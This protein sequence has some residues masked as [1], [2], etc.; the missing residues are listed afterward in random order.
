MS[1]ACVLLLLH[2]EHPIFPLSITLTPAPRL[3]YL[4][5][6]TPW[7]A[8]PATQ[9]P[10]CNI[11]K[12]GVCRLAKF[13]ARQPPSKDVGPTATAIGLFICKFPPVLLYITLANGFL[14]YFCLAR[15]LARTP[16]PC[17]A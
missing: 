9:W 17:I 3:R 7:R 10:R 16:R 14:E 12:L 8:S 6:L 2:T 11:A 1:V 4:N 13:P 15:H 5:A